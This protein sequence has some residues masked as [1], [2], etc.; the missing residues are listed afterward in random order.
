M[1][2]FTVSIAFIFCSP[3]FSP[4]VFPGPSSSDRRSASVGARYKAQAVPSVKNGDLR[5]L[6]VIFEI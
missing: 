3:L 5:P 6:F 1:L 2:R 4:S